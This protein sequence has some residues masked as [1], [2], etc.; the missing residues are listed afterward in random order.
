MSIFR[1]VVTYGF[2]KE[3]IGIAHGYT[4]MRYQSGKTRT[5]AGYKR[6][7]CMKI[8]EFE[9]NGKTEKGEIG[10]S[11]ASNWIDIYNFIKGE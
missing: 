2:K 9:A 11:N 3:I 10:I 1:E 8:V 5:S 6:Y 4:I 7:S